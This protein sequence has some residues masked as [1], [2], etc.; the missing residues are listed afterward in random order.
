MPQ[1]SG[2][3]DANILLRLLLNDVPAQHQAATKLLKEADSRFAVA[4]TALI[5]VAFVL[6]RN[7]QLNRSQ[8]VE[9]IEGLM[10][11]A[12]INCNRILFETA[13][14]FFKPNPSLSFEDCCLAAYAELNDAVPLWTF[15]KKLSS[16]ISSAKL[17]D[18]T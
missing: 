2:S 15:D 6:E 11:L 8:I 18:A 7:Y 17:I 5:E 10:A 4:D 12:E 16:Q 13:L 14:P 1:L 9:A 3:L